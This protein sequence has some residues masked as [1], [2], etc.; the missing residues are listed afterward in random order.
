MDAAM[1]RERHYEYGHTGSSHCHDATALLARKV[2]GQHVF[3][4]HAAT[5]SATPKSFFSAI[6]RV[7]GCR[8]RRHAYGKR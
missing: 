1:L 2:E 8:E 7:I 5:L 6:N 4:S 3:A